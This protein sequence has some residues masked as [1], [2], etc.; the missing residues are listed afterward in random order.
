MSS[1]IKMTFIPA[2]VANVSVLNSTTTALTGGA[3]FTGTPED[4]SQYS[5]LSVSFY[6]QP[7]NATGNIFVQ[8][9]NV[10]TNAGWIPI[11]NTVTAV[12]S[13]NASGFTLDTTMTC[14]YFRIF[15]VND[16]VAQTSFVVQSIFHPQARIAQKTTRFAE[17]PTDYSD[18][19]NT[20]T[21][22]WGKTL[23]GG[24]YEP[25]AGNG[26]NSL[27]VSVVSPLTSYGDLSTAELYPLSQFDF[28]YGINTTITSNVQYGS[29]VAITAPNSL[30]NISAGSYSMGML[31]GKKFAKYRPGQGSLS[32][33]TSYFTAGAPTA[34]LQLAGG[35]FMNPTS[36]VIVDAIGF[37]YQGSVFGVHWIKFSSNTFIAQ[38]SWNQDTLD[39]TG[40][41]GMTIIPTNINVYQVKFQWLGGGNIFYYVM[42]PLDGRWVLVHEV[43]NA[44]KITTP[45]LQ[46]PTLAMG[47]YSNNYSSTNTTLSVGGSSCAQFVEG[48]RRFLGPKGTFDY[49]QSIASGSTATPALVFALNNSLF[50]NGQPNRTQVHIR[51]VSC[52]SAGSST[53]TNTLNMRLV[54]NPTTQFASWTAYNGA[55]SAPS[56]ITGQSVVSSNVSTTNITGGTPGFSMAIAV[57]AT[58]ILD[59]SDY[60]IVL[61]PGDVLCFTSY[62]SQSNGVSS[63]S[64]NWAEDV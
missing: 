19:I 18:M 47:W 57:G 22:I 38:S 59:I 44:G 40:K 14:Q 9:S 8:F 64:V 6:V 10:S 62:S 49:Y 43:Q 1:F 34:S 55:W 61:Y 5:S 15:Y 63:I 11:S 41:S 26:E 56:S 27:C 31:R 35:L 33:F 42:N 25:I 53:S 20:R 45:V 3:T 4:V 51:S 30:L 7:T 12:S 28:V 24:I 60:E 36:N 17:T 21:I 29:N 2:V 50:F 23:G 48:N 58:N 39:G 46:N 32:R 37:G 13:T 16:S 52:A 54:R